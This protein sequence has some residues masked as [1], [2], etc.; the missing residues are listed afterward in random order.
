MVPAFVAMFEVVVEMDTFRH[1]LVAPT[2]VVGRDH[3]RHQIGESVNERTL[4]IRLVFL[5]DQLAQ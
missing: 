5:L 2:A 3:I 1:G 4:P